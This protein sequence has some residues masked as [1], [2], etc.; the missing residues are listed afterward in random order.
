MVSVLEKTIVQDSIAHEEELESSNVISIT[1]DEI[2][3]VS[4]S[5]AQKMEREA[6]LVV[7]EES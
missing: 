4:I 7:D 2:A 5:A 3:I 6:L 1:E